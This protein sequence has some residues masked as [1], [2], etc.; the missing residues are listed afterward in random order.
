M[1][2]QRRFR[3]EEID[4]L[5]AI[6]NQIGV[7]IENAR[8][9]EWQRDSENRYRTIF[10]TT[11]A[12]S[13]IIEEDTTISLAN[14][15]FEKLSGYSREEVEGKKSWTEFVVEDHLERMKEY[16]RLRRIDT[17][18]A[19]DNYEFRFVDRWGN[20]KDIFL[21]IATIPGTKKSVASLSDVTKLKRV[22]EQIRASEE[23]YRELFESAN[24]AIWLHDLQG[25][26]IAANRS[27]VRLTGYTVEEVHDIKAGN[28]ITEDCRDNVKELE[29]LLLRGEAKGH[30]SEATLVKKDKSETSVQLSTSPISSNG[31]LVG[32]QH[33]ARDVTEEKRMRENLRFH[34][35]EVT[36][37]QEEERKRIA[38]ELHDDT[39]QALVVLSRHLDALASGSEGLPK[40][41]RL[42]LENLWQQTNKVM[43]GV[44]RLS[45]DL[46]PATLDRLGLVSAIEWLAED[47]AKYSGI[48]IKVNVNGK[49]RRLPEEK[50]L[51]LF[52]IAQEALRNVWRHSQ[53]S[54]AEVTIEFDKGKIITTISDNGQ[55]FE[56]PENMSDLLTGGKLGL[57]GMQERAQLLGTTLT[58]ESKAGKG[59]SISVEVET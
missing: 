23:R 54:E 43:E 33:I 17:K 19:P 27:F 2:S 22:E 29:D 24:D 55:G 7:A 57:A 50:E 45:Q 51:V 4:L 47:V 20:V 35:Q 9:Y 44:R 5:T 49:I 34:L 30:L 3:Q 38:R 8:L 36:K 52:R 25:N 41:K 18:S 13:V 1:R 10:E 21:N 14:V 28:L 11:G 31:Q 37:A 12:A 15:E 16:H 6:G 32:F 56:V 26:I 53:A 48:Q 40:D 42:L 39:I 59:T 58:I 46:R